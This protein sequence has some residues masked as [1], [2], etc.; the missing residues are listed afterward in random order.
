M[1]SLPPPRRSSKRPLSLIA[2]IVTAAVSA[3]CAPTPVPSPTPTA[4]F[5]SR[6]EAFAAAEQTYRAYTDALNHVD[7]A[8]PVTF[9]NTYKFSSGNFRR[10]DR[11]NFS[12]MHAKGYT[13]DGDALVIR[14]VGEVSVPPY[15]R[16]RAIVCLDVSH[17]SVRD[18]SGASVVNPNRPDI[19]ELEVN[20]KS[21]A[22]RLRIDSAER[23][24]GKT[25]TNH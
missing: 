6:E 5:A 21:S 12:T 13:I 9:E 2:L 23:I 7:P 22:G 8:Q 19:Y 3:G 11:K 25:C 15:D 1:T 14:F 4:A 17:V 16:V 18:Q 24:E 20:F 10:A